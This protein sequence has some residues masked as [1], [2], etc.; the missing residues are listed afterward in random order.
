MAAKTWP[1]GGSRN[2]TCLRRRDLAGG[3]HH[4]KHGTCGNL[5]T[6]N[7][8]GFIW[9][10]LMFAPSISDLRGLSMK[11]TAFAALA[12]LGV[13]VSGCATIIDGTSQSLSVNTTPEGGAQ[14]TLV[15]GE[16][17]WYVT[18]PGSTT[19]HKTK[20]DLD[21]T[22][23]KPGFK[24]AHLVSPSHFTGKTAGNLLLG[25]GGVVIGGAVDAASGA[26]YHYDPVIDVP[27]G[28]ADT[29]AASSA[30]APVTTASNK[31][32]S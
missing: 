28:A 29:A 13:A 6:V 27:L 20:T 25:V 11:F 9:R 8:C 17:T 30:S 1:E 22:C 2:D 26:N 4:L 15:N 19:V 21:V 23:T 24:T 14:C 5:A 10:C 7:R 31:P 18:T 16:G 3:V 12:A 32:T